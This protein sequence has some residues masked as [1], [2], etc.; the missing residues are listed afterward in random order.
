M[1]QFQLVIAMCQNRTLPD[2]FSNTW[3]GFIFAT[4]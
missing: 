2:D 4:N 3:A 1:T